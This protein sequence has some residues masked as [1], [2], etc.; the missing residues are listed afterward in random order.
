MSRV[1]TIRLRVPAWVSDED[2]ERIVREIEEMLESS[3]PVDVL[4]SMLGVKEEDLVDRLEAVD[5]ER[6]E[7]K[8]KERLRRLYE[9]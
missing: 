7:E 2:V 5:W 8:E 6:I 1:V 3:M 4:R 9:S